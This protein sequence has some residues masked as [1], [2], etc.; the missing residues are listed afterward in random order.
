MSA[1]ILYILLGAT[2]CAGYCQFKYE[3]IRNIL[4]YCFPGQN[5]T[6]LKYGIDL[7]KNLSDKY[8][9]RQ[10]EK[11]PVILIVDDVSNF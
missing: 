9:L 6:F 4:V 2:K 1:N 5:K 11:Y 10:Q 7:I 8:N 3:D